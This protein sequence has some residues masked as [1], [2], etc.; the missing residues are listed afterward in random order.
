LDGEIEMENLVVLLQLMMLP[1]MEKPL[2]IGYE[3]EGILP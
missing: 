2:E 1:S 3:Y